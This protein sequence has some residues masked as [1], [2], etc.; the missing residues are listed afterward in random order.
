MRPL[1]GPLAATPRAFHHV[2]EGI[3]QK[4]GRAA[5]RIEDAVGK[6]RPDHADHEL[7]DV[8]GRAVKPHVLRAAGFG[9]GRLDGVAEQVG[10]QEAVFVDLAHEGEDLLKVAALDVVREVGVLEDFL[11]QDELVLHLLPQVRFVYL[12][13]LGKDAGVEGEEL[14]VECRQQQVVGF[15]VE[16]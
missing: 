11:N 15:R 1:A 16:G 5:G 8:V 3:E 6:C 14:L 7:P 12:T 13:G 4:A 2:A 9:E 10:L